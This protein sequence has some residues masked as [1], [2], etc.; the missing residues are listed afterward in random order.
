MRSIYEL[1]CENKHV[2]FINISLKWKIAAIIFCLFAI[3]HIFYCIL[4]ERLKCES[5]PKFLLFDISNENNQKS[6]K[7]HEKTAK[8]CKNSSEV[9]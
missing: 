4:D 6:S 7:N 5:F 8:I 3:M 2:C 9:K 1:I